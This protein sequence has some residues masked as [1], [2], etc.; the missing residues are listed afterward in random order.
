MVMFW[1]N[2]AGEEF[3]LDVVR[4]AI[5]CFQKQ[6]LFSFIYPEYSIFYQKIKQ[7]IFFKK[8]DIITQMRRHLMSLKTSDCRFIVQ[9][10]S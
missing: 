1:A 9:L 4:C 10:E 8:L 5:K 2:P 6:I 3:F 7:S